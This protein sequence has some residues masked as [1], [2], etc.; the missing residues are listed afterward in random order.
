MGFF[1]PGEWCQK[2]NERF[3]FTRT[4]FTSILT[5]LCF[6]LLHLTLLC[7]P[8]LHSASLHF[9]VFSSA[10]LR[11]TSFY[12]PF[13][14]FAL[15]HILLVYLLHV[16]SLSPPL[17]SPTLCPYQSQFR[18][19]FRKH[20][21]SPTQT[22]PLLCSI[23]SSDSAGI[24]FNA[25]VGQHEALCC[26]GGFMLCT[27]LSTVCSFLLA[28]GQFGAA[29]SRNLVDRRNGKWLLALFAG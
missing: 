20:N 11:F 5:S 9:T 4:N 27:F 19:T 17:P 1:K 6:P 18:I 13:L 29:I 15:L 23:F 7:F 8:S 12:F 25:V 3:H 26:Q 28:L 10:L 22:T 2:W 16:T 24:Y 14:L 21:P